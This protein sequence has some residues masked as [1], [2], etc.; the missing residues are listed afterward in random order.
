ML[1]NNR[2]RTKIPDPAAP[3]L[4]PAPRSRTFFVF[5]ASASCGGTN[6]EWWVTGGVGFHV[7]G[8]GTHNQ[9]TKYTPEQSVVAYMV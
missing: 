7:W 4:P 9:H 3:L 5:A 1:D 2:H 6:M 8:L